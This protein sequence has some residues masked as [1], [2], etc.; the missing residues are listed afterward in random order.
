MQTRENYAEQQLSTIE[1]TLGFKYFSPFEDKVLSSCLEYLSGAEYKVISAIIKKTWRYQKRLAEIG[2]RQI[3]KMITVSFGH[4]NRLIIKLRAKNILLVIDQPK[5]H[6]RVLSINPDVKSWLV[7][8]KDADSLKEEVTEIEELEEYLIE[9]ARVEKE[10]NER[11]KKEARRKARKLSRKRKKALKRQEEKSSKKKKKQKSIKKQTTSEPKTVETSTGVVPTAVI[12]PNTESKSTSDSSTSISVDDVVEVW[13][14]VCKTS[15]RDG[16]L[17]GMTPEEI[18]SP[19]AKKQIEVLFKYPDFQNIDAFKYAFI[20]MAKVEVLCGKGDFGWVANLSWATRVNKFIEYYNK[21]YA[22]NQK[23]LQ[24]EEEDRKRKEAQ[25]EVER[26]EKEKR[27]SREIARLLK[28]TSE[29]RRED[30]RTT[31]ED[32]RRMNFGEESL[33][34][35][36]A[37]FD[38]VEELSRV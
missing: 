16:E 29:E 21:W 35:V 2:I 25:A 6:R 18:V 36:K 33:V 4:V 31:I 20:G 34:E 22:W 13:N 19:E 28:M 38:K 27:E 10:E 5:G 9:L 7:G 37:L 8:G 17:E 1:R 26:L 30:Y 11:K 14:E 12:K 32:F 15:C 24:E 23:R 3:G